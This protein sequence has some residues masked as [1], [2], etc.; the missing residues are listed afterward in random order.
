SVIVVELCLSPKSNSAYK[1]LDKAMHIV[2]KGKTYD[3]PNHLKD[4]H[5]QGAKSLGH[6]DSY[7]YQHHYP[8]GWVYQEYLPKELQHKTFYEPNEV[9]N[10]QRLAKICNF[11]KEIQYKNRK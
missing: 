4:T 2:K 11:L 9:G 1:A 7:K 3:I 5:Y 8:N 10:K 6:G